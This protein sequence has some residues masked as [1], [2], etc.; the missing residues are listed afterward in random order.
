MDGWNNNND[1]DG[2]KD[3]YI[4]M[5]GDPGDLVYDWGD[6]VE[7]E[8]A[9]IDLGNNKSQPKVWHN[10]NNINQAENADGSNILGKIMIGLI[11]V[12]ILL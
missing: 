6:Q 3:F 7:L 8:I 9:A 10:Q 4:T 1:V 11:L 2:A 12:G 5:G